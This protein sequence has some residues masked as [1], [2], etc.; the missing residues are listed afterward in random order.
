LT[1]T[2]RLLSNVDRR[3][4]CNAITLGWPAKV[5]ICTCR[6]WSETWGAPFMAKALINGIAQAVLI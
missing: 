4:G 2:G 1:R 5:N 6:D 3:Q